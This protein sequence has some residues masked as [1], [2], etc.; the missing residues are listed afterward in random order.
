MSQH[1]PLPLGVPP[2]APAV[3]ITGAA[4]AHGFQVPPAPATLPVFRDVAPHGA[5][6]GSP[7]QPAPF[8][9]AGRTDLQVLRRQAAR[10]E[11]SPLLTQLLEAMPGAACIINAHRQ[12][13]AANRHLLFTI[14][15]PALAQALG[16]RPG[17]AL[18]CVRAHAP[19]DGCGTTAWC[20]TCGVAKALKTAATER[21]TVT[22]ECRVTVARDGRTSLDLEATVTPLEFEGEL[23]TVLSLRDLSGEKRRDVLERVFF[24]D[25]LNTAGGIHGLA[26]LTADPETAADFPEA[27]VTLARLAAQLVEEIELQ[28][29]LRAAERGAYL[30]SLVLTEVRG[31]LEDVAMLY[32]A[33]DVAR[34]RTVQVAAGEPV[35]WITDP[36]IL[37]R[38]LGN[39]VKNALEASPRGG[40]V[41]LSAT[42]TEAALELRVHNAG[43]MPPEV[44]AQVFQRSFS[45][46][47]GV[48]RGIGSYSVQLFAERVLGGQVSFTSSAAEG[49]TFVVHF[50]DA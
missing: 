31:L 29:A 47:G 34:R 28:R 4:E 49:T 37:R 5:G 9:P 33:H 10:A 16:Q 39:L 45:T 19:P 22:G 21:R 1:P 41:T 6:H 11:A 12:I 46:K 17:E 7:G 30:P 14:G 2:A 26:R 25:V 44:Q 24:H 23:F 50:P 48:G 18:A 36:V 35:A 32:R 8:L 20:A 13:I 27:P 43:V 38:V 3:E 42:R 15:V 40:T